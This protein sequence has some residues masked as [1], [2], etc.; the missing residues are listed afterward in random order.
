[1]TDPFK[2]A[3]IQ[4]GSCGFDTEGGVEKAVSLI[5]DAA[6]A[7]VRVAVFPEAFLGSYPKGI[8]FGTRLGSRTD[9]G[10][11]QFRRYFEAAI[12]I[13]GP[14]TER[15]AEMAIASGMHVVIGVI[16]RG[17]G[18]LYCTALLLGPDGR[19]L[20]RHRKLM[21]TAL[22]R[23][24]WGMGD[25]SMMAVA[26]TAVG[27]IGTAICWE[28]YM[29]LYRTHLYGQGVSLYCAPTVDDREVWQATIRHIAREGRCFVLS[30]CQHLRRRDLP[31]DFD[32]RE[33][34]EP[35][36][37]LIRGGSAI[38]SPLGDLL[39]GPVYDED[40]ILVAELDP[41]DLARGKFDFDAVGH[42]ARPDIFDLRIRNG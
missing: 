27:T 20:S 14:E 34:N 26:R 35:D 10:R 5:A 23:L 2:A 16:E 18:T 39:A 15:L 30:A 28:N 36:R 19:I 32:C 11:D 9:E 4:A 41:R 13:P 21:P 6:A 33:G 37:I 8:D 12:D 42:Y 31:Q 38:V 29:P 17:G 1:M 40:A 22:E 7:G 3:V 24:I 25:A